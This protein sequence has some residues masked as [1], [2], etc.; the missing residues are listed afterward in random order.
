MKYLF[1]L[2]VLFSCKKEK[3]ECE[4]QNGVYLILNN[5]NETVG[6]FNSRFIKINDIDYGKSYGGHHDTVAVENIV[7]DNKIGGDLKLS[8]WDG[9][10]LTEPS[11]FTLHFSKQCEYQTFDI[12]F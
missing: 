7:Y 1:L 11:I 10:S 12:K 6:N 2:L 4:K 3:R 5:F 9:S 8:I